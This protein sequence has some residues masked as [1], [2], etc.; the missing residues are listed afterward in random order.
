MEIQYYKSKRSNR[1]Y[2]D[3][4]K[5]TSVEKNTCKEIVDSKDSDFYISCKKHHISIITV[6]ELKKGEDYWIN[7]KGVKYNFTYDTWKYSIG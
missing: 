1:I 7:I 4:E 3:F 2:I 6:V 5:N